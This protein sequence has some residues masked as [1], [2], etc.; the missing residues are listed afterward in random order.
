VDYFPAAG[1]QTKT[2]GFGGEVTFFGVPKRRLY[3]LT[4]PK[5]R[6]SMRSRTARA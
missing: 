4:C 5:K 2:H 3:R 6:R 1:G